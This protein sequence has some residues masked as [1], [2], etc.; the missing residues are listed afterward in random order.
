LL[1]GADLALRRANLVVTSIIVGGV[2][3]AQ[4]AYQ[5]WQVDNVLMPDTAIAPYSNRW[6][7]LKGLSP[8]GPDAATGALTVTGGVALT[9]VPQGTVYQLSPGIT[10]QTTSAETLNGSGNA[11]LPIQAILP[12]PTADGPPDGT[13]WNVDAGATM[14]LVQAIPGVPGTATVAANISNGTAPETNSAFIARYLVAFQKPP[15]GGDFNDYVTWALEAPGVTRAWVNPL[16]KGPGTVVVYI[17]LDVVEAAFNGFPQ[18]TNG[19][20]ASETRDT[21]ATGDQ[22]AAA[23][24]IYPLRNVTALVYLFAPTPAAQNFTV[25]GAPVGQQ[26]LVAAGIAAVLLAEGAA[27]LINPLTYAVTGGQVSIA[28]LQ[29]AVRVVPQ[30]SQAVVTSPTGQYIKTS[31]GQLPTLGFVSIV[32]PNSGNVGNGAIPTVTPSTGVVLNA[33]YTIAFTSATAFTVTPP[34]G[35]TGGS[36]T[37]GTPYSAGDLAFTIV[38]GTTAFAAGDGFQITVAT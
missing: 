37:V 5:D 25:L 27:A 26:A 3:D 11:T 28:D 10:Y 33:A 23:N 38:A 34:A 1:T 22:L 12:A 30:C 6:G 17:M 13:Q 29:A 19:V 14:T 20:A 9:P 4:Y 35:G 15:Q 32:A 24:F 8:N 31:I 7:A 2:A 16:Q 36:G 21:P 18:G